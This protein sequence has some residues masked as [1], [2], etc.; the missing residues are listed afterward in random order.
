M[1]D[2]FALVAFIFLV[3]WALTTY[4]YRA[5]KHA[6]DAERAE[7]LSRIQARSAAEYKALRDVDQGPARP[8]VRR[9]PVYQSHTMPA[10]ADPV[11]DTADAQMTYERLP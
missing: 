2:P 8:V 1:T 7:L 5:D 6:W 4:F 3:L 9:E 10:A 11:M